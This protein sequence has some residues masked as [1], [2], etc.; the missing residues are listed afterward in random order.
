MKN[1]SLISRSIDM[2]FLEPLLRAADPSV[3]VV[4]WPDPRS[5]QAEVAVC[6]DPPRGIFGE[7]PNLQ[8][9]HSIAAGVDNVVSEQD[10]RGLPVCRVVDPM[11]AEGMWQFVLW[12]VL[13]YH[14]KLDYAMA[15]QRAH[16]WSRPLQTPSSATCVGVMGL[17]ELGGLVASRLPA[18]GY[19][20]NGW[21]SSPRK[22][23][24]VTVYSGETGL[25]DFLAAT[26][27]LV[28]LLPLTPQT[29]GILTAGPS[30]HCPRT[31]R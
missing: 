18:L 19:R 17:G 2:G 7:M 23:A 28:C 26:D 5:L 24:G 20:V 31:Q 22:L 29:R 8:M 16:E 9:V 21:A 3:N 6:W 12:G 10:L 4:T 14:R 15:S 25:A 30:T 1:I 27:I 11:L 13:Y